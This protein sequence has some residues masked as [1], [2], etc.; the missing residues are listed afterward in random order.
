MSEKASDYELRF[1]EK[2]AL[3]NPDFADALVPLAE[4]YTRRGLY[5]KGLQ[6]DARLAQLRKDDP[7]VHYNLACSLALVGKAEDAVRALKRAIRLGYRDL[8]YMSRDPDL[9]SLHTASG[10]QKLLQQKSEGKN[11]EKT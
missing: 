8:E 2:L 9:K 10:F 3:K 1:F 11:N 4:L 5:E 7:F 6:V